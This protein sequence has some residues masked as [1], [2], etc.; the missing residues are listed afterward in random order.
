MIYSN[1]TLPREE[2][3]YCADCG[4]KDPQLCIQDVG[5][6]PYE[7]WGAR[8]NDVQLVCV[9]RCCGA[10]IVDKAGNELEADCGGGYEKEFEYPDA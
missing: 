7:L 10:G 3:I 9:T 4:Q 5:I 8:G 6:G 1:N 2:G